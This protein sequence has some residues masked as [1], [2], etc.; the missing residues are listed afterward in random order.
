MAKNVS[1]EEQAAAQAAD[2]EKTKEELEWAEKGSLLCRIK[3][4]V[5]KL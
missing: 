1:P 2:E 3:K 5:F 4:Y